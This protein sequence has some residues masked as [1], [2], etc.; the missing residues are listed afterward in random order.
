MYPAHKFCFEVSSQ[1][2]IQQEVVISVCML[3]F[4]RFSLLQVLVWHKVGDDV[5]DRQWKD[6]CMRFCFYCILPD[7]RD[8]IFGRIR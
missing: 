4:M 2:F 7:V 3:R 1:F 8:P 6:W 5:W